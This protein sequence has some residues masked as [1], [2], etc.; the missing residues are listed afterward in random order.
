MIRPAGKKNRFITSRVV[1][2]G[3]KI[4]KKRTN[5]VTSAQ[6]LLL[7]LIF[8]HTLLHVSNTRNRVLD[9]QSQ[10]NNSG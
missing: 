6:F 10:Y 1:Q 4:Y 8:M 9:G 5:D 3:N 7:V 2:T